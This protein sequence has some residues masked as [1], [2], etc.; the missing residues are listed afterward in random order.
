MYRSVLTRI[1]ILLA[2]FLAS[3]GSYGPPKYIWEAWSKPGSSPDS[4]RADMS[5][6]GY[7]KNLNTGIDL[8]NEQIRTVHL[9]M[10]GK[11][12]SFDASSYQADNCY[13]PN[14]PYPCRAY[15]SGGQS[16]SKVVQPTNSK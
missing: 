13:G 2:V 12:Y 9:C 16:Q 5:A 7:G 14:A 15:W 8:A 10:Q 4:V 1:I 3:C 11:G 6:C